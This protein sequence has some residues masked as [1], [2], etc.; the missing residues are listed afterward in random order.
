M[1]GAKISAYIG[2]ALGW[3]SW[4][5][6]LVGTFAGFA[7]AAVCGGILLSS[8]R[9]TLQRPGRRSCSSGFLDWR[10]SCWRRAAGQGGAPAAKRKLRP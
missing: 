8:S 2:H 4:Q 3:P 7:L 10:R 5:A 9:L 6:L 1:A